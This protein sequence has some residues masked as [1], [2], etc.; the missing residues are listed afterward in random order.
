VRLRITGDDLLAAGVP[1]GPEI[2]RLLEETLRLRLD[3]E[4]PDEREPQLQA[5]LGL[6]R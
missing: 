1:E 3:G 6:L 4:L 5:A 2:G